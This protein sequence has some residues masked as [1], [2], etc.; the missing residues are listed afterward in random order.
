MNIKRTKNVELLIKKKGDITKLAIGVEGGLQDEKG[1]EFYLY[2]NS[3][4][5][6]K[7]NHV[8]KDED[9]D[10]T[11]NQNSTKTKNLKKNKIHSIWSKKYN[12]QL[13]QLSLSPFLKKKTNRSK[14]QCKA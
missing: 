11:V 7:C 5:C 13:D 10:Q 4:F 8:L 2:D 3:A 6:F 9:L 12:N 14:I 1:E